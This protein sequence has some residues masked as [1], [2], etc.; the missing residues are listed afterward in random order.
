MTLRTAIDA[1]AIWAGAGLAPSPN[2]FHRH[3]G[4]AAATC[5][6]G[7]RTVSTAQTRTEAYGRPTG[8]PR[9]RRQPR[10][11]SAAS[12]YIGVLVSRREVRTDDCDVTELRDRAITLAEELLNRF[13]VDVTR[14][15]RSSRQLWLRAQPRTSVGP[16]RHAGMAGGQLAPP[17]RVPRRTVAQLAGHVR[18][19]GHARDGSLVMG[20]QPRCTSAFWSHVVRCV[21]T[22]E[23]SPSCA[24]GPL[25]SPRSCSTASA[26]T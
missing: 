12:L 15:L 23:T 8:R 14:I 10:D 13:G 9:A 16:Q 5:W 21:P 19:A 7:R 22:T 18:D 20:R 11:G 2:A 17:R 24:I 1:L 6:H 25:R 26:S 3:V 4:R